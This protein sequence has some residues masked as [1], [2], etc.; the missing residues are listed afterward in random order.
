MSD[1][2]LI[3]FDYHGV[4]DRRGYRGLMLAIARGAGTEPSEAFFARLE[5]MVYLYAA[6]QTVPLEFWTKLSA[7]YGAS[8]ADAGRKY[9]LH[10]DPIHPMW[11]LL[12]QLHQTVELGLCTDSALDKKE[13]IRHA[14]DLPTFFD[15]LVFSCDLGRTKHDPF[16]YQALL[17]GHQYQSGDILLIDDDEKNVAMAQAAGIPAFLHVSPATTI[18]F[19]TGKKSI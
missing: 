4:L 6:G 11:V 13:V 10:V 14:Y 3:Y 12:N 2:R 8:A 16:F 1:R 9:Y 7:Q 5:P 18:R 19:L 17:Q 15:Q